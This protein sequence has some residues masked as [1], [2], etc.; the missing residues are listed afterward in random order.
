MSSVQLTIAKRLFDRLWAVL[1]VGVLWE[2]VTRFH[3]VDVD[4]LPP[5]SAILW[6]IG[7]MV[8]DGRIVW[9]TAL[10]GA[11]AIGGLFLA[12]ATGVP[13]GLTLGYMY[14]SVFVILQPI[15]RVLSHINP[16][17][18]MPVFFL[19]LGLGNQATVVVV[20]WMAFWPI[21]FYT[22]AGVSEVDPDLIYIGRSMAASRFRLAIMVVLPG[23][24]PTMFAG[25]R[26]ASTIIFFSLVGVEMLGTTGGLGWLVH[27]CAMNYQIHGIYAAAIVV[28]VL[29]YVMQLVLADI[30]HRLL[31]RSSLVDSDVTP[32]S[33]DHNA[34]PCDWKAL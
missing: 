23:A 1:A 21:V 16:F 11:R 34:F 4:F 5:L 26:V 30:H 6:R 31:A 14:P 28:V 15:L 13:L 8:L 18:L 17:S 10:S 20:A 9:H 7:G 19:F 33:N 12:L 2:G 3:W 22:V 29:G 32:N 25:V 27:N 24:L